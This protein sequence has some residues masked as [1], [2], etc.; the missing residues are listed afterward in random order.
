MSGFCHKCM[1][2]TKVFGSW[3][4]VGEPAGLAVGIGNPNE[5]KQQQTVVKTVISLEYVVVA[6]KLLMMMTVRLLEVGGG[7][8]WK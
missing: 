8:E 4:W 6:V 1:V 3:S 2:V 7:V 5:L